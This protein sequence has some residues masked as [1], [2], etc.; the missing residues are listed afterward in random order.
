[1]NNV[2]YIIFFIY[3]LNEKKLIEKKLSGVRSHV[4]ESF[5]AIYAP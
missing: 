2:V 4:F 1:M 5:I 3:I